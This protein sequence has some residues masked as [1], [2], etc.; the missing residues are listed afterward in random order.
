MPRWVLISVWPVAAVAACGFN[1]E[2]G[3]K[4]PAS[5]DWSIAVP[6]EDQRVACGLRKDGAGF[7]CSVAVRPTAT[8]GQR[9]V[10]YCSNNAVNVDTFQLGCR[11][12]G[13]LCDLT[14]LKQIRKEGS[15]AVGHLRAE[16]QVPV[17]QPPAGGYD[18]A[19]PVRLSGSKVVGWYSVTGCTGKVVEIDN[20][21]GGQSG[22]IDLRVP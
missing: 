17:A 6:A 14:T 2:D 19:S 16:N 7:Q 20:G 22:W 1:V 8:A 15:C 18:V 21:Q 13:T 4:K 12:K 5:P 9:E 10:V 11:Q 3:T